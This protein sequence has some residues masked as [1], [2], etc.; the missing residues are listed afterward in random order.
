ML[1]MQTIKDLFVY[2]YFLAKH[3]RSEIY[4]RYFWYKSKNN[5]SPCKHVF[6][7][8]RLAAQQ[9]GVTD[10][11]LSVAMCGIDYL[12]IP[13]PEEKQY[14][15]NARKIAKNNTTFFI[16]NFELCLGTLRRSDKFSD[17]TRTNAGHAFKVIQYVNEN[18]EVRYKFLQSY[19][20]QYTLLKYLKRVESGEIQGDFSHEEFMTFIQ[21]LEAIKS[22]R[23]WSDAQELYQKYFHVNH[24]D[25][26]EHR[27]VT[28]SSIKVFY[29]QGDLNQA[30][31]A[32]KTFAS[33]RDSKHYPG[34]T[35]IS[36]DNEK[37]CEVVS[38]AF[39]CAGLGKD[40]A[41]DGGYGLIFK[42]ILLKPTLSAFAKLKD[43]TSIFNTTEPGVKT[44]ISENETPK[45]VMSSNLK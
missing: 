44:K 15:R 38:K 37:E 2:L 23:D 3:P 31:E 25:Y 35:F 40:S 10:I 19:V 12:A 21:D 45:P 13:M 7:E 24:Q 34:F 43:G 1:C 6:A 17:S 39:R 5:T 36:G 14:R 4:A 11:G 22:A 18:L 9:C 26:K 29:L 20:G 30:N 33:H 32:K 8:K 16:Y 41:L 42:K 27:F 28:Q